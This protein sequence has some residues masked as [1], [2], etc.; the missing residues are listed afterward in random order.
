ML[1]LIKK[2]MS[3]RCPP[4]FFDNYIFAGLTNQ[5]S[6]HIKDDKSWFPV[7]Y[8]D[9]TRTENSNIL[10]GN[11]LFRNF[12]LSML[13]DCYV[14]HVSTCMCVYRSEGRN[15]TAK[16]CLPTMAYILYGDEVFYFHSL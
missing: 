7:L 14:L 2:S 3:R 8:M 11:H 15:H 13:V 4:R 16:V 6:F 9:R 12:Q 10:Y 5:L 1:F